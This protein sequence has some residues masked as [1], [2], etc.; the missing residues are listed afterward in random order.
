MSS[1]SSEH[2]WE[3][4]YPDEVCQLSGFI[5]SVLDQQMNNL[6]RNAVPDEEMRYPVDEPK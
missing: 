4:L 2:S 5:K 1:A 6:P 3:D